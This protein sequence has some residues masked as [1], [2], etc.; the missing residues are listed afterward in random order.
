MSVVIDSLTKRFGA[1]VAVDGVSVAIDHGEFFCILG[2]SGCGKST[3]LRLVAGLETADGGSVALSGE[4]VTGPGIHVPPEDRK[5]GFVFQSYALW[6]HMSV[7]D[8]VAFPAEAQGHTKAEARRLALAHL[9]TV[10]LTA[11]AERKPAALS[12]G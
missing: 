6:P 9:E 11:Y 5:C 12:G 8:N 2:A 1:E 7:L 3:L 10:S 4:T